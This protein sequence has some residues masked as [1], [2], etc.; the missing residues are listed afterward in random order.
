MMDSRMTSLRSSDTI[1]GSVRLASARIS[2][3]RFARAMGVPDNT[4]HGGSHIVGARGFQCQQSEADLAVGDD[5]RD[6]LINLV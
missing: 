1:C 6:R 4:F 3:D 2:L 5:R